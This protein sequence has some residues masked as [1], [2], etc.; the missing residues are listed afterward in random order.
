MDTDM[1]N[2]ICRVAGK[3]VYTAETVGKV[4]DENGNETGSYKATHKDFMTEDLLTVANP[5]FID[6]KAAT[7]W[8]I[9]DGLPY[10]LSVMPMAKCPAPEINPAK[11]LPTP[12]ASAQDLI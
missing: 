6:G 11:R 7:C 3:D 5:K 4:L 12:A 2:D 10:P 1:A 8:V 9:G